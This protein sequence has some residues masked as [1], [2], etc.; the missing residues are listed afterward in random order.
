MDA[1]MKRILVL[2]PHT[3]DAELG[4]G[5]TIVRML[6][7]G[8]EIH[9][10]VFSTAEESLPEHL[11]KDTLKR[12]FQNVMDHLGLGKD[13]YFIFNFKVRHLQE[14]RQQILEHMVQINRE[15]KPEL[16]VGPSLKDVHQDHVVVANEMV[17]AY[18]GTSSII[19]YELPWNHLTFDTQMFVRLSADQ[20]EQKLDLLKHYKSQLIKGRS[21]FSREFILG[22]AKTRGIQLGAE[23]AEAFEVIRWIV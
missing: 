11:P 4:C 12:E 20:L 5:G 19:S 14:E 1:S 17:R 23:Y 9:W 3:D 15:F 13:S 21:Y 8:V 22:L 18:K 10:V 16:V 6:R 7:E 2:S